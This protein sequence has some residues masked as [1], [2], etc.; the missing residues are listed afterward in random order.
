MKIILAQTAGFC[1]GVNRAVNMVNELLEKGVKVH[2]LGPIIHNPQVV[3]GFAA[4]GVSILEK[5]TDVPQGESVIIRA[6]G[7]PA[8]VYEQM[9]Q[10]GISYYDGTCPFVLK[11]HKIVSQAPEDTVVLIA[12]NHNHPEVAGIAGHCNGKYFIFSS[13]EEL[14]STLKSEQIQPDCAIVMV[15]QTTFSVKEWN[16]CSNFIKKDYTNAKIFDTICNATAQRQEEAVKLSSQVDMMIVIGG[17]TSSNTSKLYHV[18]QENCKSYLI[19]KA[20]EIKQIDFSD[21]KSVG[22]TAGA[23]TPDG[24]IKEVLETMSEIIKENEK[25]NDEEMSFEQLFAES[26][27]DEDTTD[28]H[29]VGT[30]IQIT[31]SEVF[32][33]AGRKETGVVKLEDL[34]DDPSAKIEDLVK[35]GDKLDLIIM[36]TNNAE[37]TMQLS[38]KLFDARKGW[39]DIAQAKESGEIMEGTVTDVIRGGVLVATNAV[40]IFIP[41]SLSGVPKGE[42]VATLKGQT[43]KFRIIDVNPQRRRA[44]GSIRSVLREERK[45]AREAL[46]A[47]IEE[48]QVYTGK[49]KS[50]T[51]YGAF[52]D[53][54]GVDGMIH[55]TELSWNR[56]KH[57]QDI[58]NIGDEVEVYVKAV[59]KENKKISLGYKKEADNPWI[60]LQNDYPVDS[61][62]PVKIVGLTTFGAFANI[63]DGID[64]LIHISQIA[65]KRIS[66]PADVLKIGDEVEAKITEID[67]DKKRVSLSIRALLPEEEYVEE[68]VAEEAAEEVAETPA[69]EA[70]EEVA[71]APVEE[72][73][74]EVA[75]AP[76]EEATEEVAE[77]PAEEAA[78][79]VAEAPAEEAVEEVA[80]APVEEAVEEVAEAPVEEATEE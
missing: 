49:V 28:S 27:K 21:C 71:E 39:F 36:K 59:D 19:E 7:V 29:V 16:L 43:V 6:H 52:V 32:V 42:D 48:G 8:S 76:A 23:S 30:V 54:G 61:V 3:E 51:S 44:V 26:I 15:S 80:E 57:P 45:A 79:E 1:F 4:R 25:I 18:C 55:I 70:V 65:N 73:A 35:I 53:I 58:V 37:G 14:K 24:I 20:D 68:E 67:S 60:K 17:R 46:W 12:G 69:E 2:T 75:E 62:V 11:I 72:A 78:E 77:A 50:L 40:K 74:E 38:K 33:D 13:L 56:I 5:V 22:V 10:S 64:G 31:P 34:T 9:E 47:S 41:A 63:I 66:K